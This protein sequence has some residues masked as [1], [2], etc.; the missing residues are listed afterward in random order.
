MA[1]G[2]AV[3]T[4]RGQPASRIVLY[5][6]APLGLEP[7]AYRYRICGST[8]L[9]FRNAVLYTWLLESFYIVRRK[10]ALFSYALSND[11]VDLDNTDINQTRYPSSYHPFKHK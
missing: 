1:A 2:V 7:V 4:T 11:T 3:V 6:P 10:A 8:Q 9:G 5:I